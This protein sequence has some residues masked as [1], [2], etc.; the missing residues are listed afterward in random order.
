MTGLEF[1]LCRAG[2]H[3]FG[4]EAAL[5]RR[6][7][8]FGSAAATRLETCLGLSD[9]GTQDRHLLR[10]RAAHGDW[11]LD[12][13]GPLELICLPSSRI[14]SLPPLL[15]L[16]SPLPGLR[17]LALV[18]ANAPNAPNAPGESLIWLLDPRTLAM[19]G[20]DNSLQ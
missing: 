19:P 14:Q 6:A 15:A 11:D 20:S 7:L 5:V 8:T 12:V 4:F 1:V 9:D 10:L 2:D 13:A 3:C 17:A 18:P 16:R